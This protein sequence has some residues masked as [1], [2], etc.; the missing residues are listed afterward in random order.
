M[1]SKSAQGIVAEQYVAEQVSTL[2]RWKRSRGAYLDIQ[3]TSTT[4]L[5]S[6][7][8]REIDV[9]SVEH[10]R[11]F[12]TLNE[13]ALNKAIDLKEAHPKLDVLFV[14]VEVRK[15]SLSKFEIP[16]KPVDDVVRVCDV[17]GIKEFIEEGGIL[18]NEGVYNDGSKYFY[19]PRWEE[20][21]SVPFSE[22]FE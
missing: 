5:L 21:L 3:L 4:R 7:I 1:H 6:P 22:V 10:D 12:W 13:R 11:H 9:K 20:R 17:Q 8:T 18:P 15:I 14:V 16:S 19:V 2:S